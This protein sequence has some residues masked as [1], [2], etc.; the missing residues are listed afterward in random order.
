MQS[1]GKGE[2]PLVSQPRSVGLIELQQV[3]KF[4]RTSDVASPVE[5]EMTIATQAYEY[6]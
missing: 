2:Q 6:L 5:I 1:A 4:T 3:G